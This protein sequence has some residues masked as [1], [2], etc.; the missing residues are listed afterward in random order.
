MEMSLVE[1][2]TLG[3]GRQELQILGLV[4]NSIVHTKDDY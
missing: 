3:K 4:G 1:F 2:Y